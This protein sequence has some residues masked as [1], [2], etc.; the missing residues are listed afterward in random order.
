MSRF[1]AKIT[2]GHVEFEKPVEYNP[3]REAQQ[4]IRDINHY[5]RGETY[6]E[7]IDWGSFAYAY[8]S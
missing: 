4:E 6:V 8:N 3:A 7:V 2:L 1:V 5:V